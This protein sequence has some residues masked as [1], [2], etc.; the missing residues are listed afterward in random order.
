MKSST[1]RTLKKIFLNITA[2]LFALIF[3]GNIIAGENAGQINQVLGTKTSKTISTLPAGQE[4]GYAR[5]FDSAFTSIAQLKAAGEAKV[6]EVEGEGIVLLK[7]DNAVLPLASGS[8]V[9]LVGVTVMDPVYGGTGSGAVDADGAP[10]YY[11]VLTGAGYDVVDKA[12]LDY[13]VENEAKRNTYEIGE[14]R[15]KKVSKNNDDTIGQGEDAI[16]VVGRVGGEG[17]DVTAEKEDALDGDYLTLNEDEISILEG[18]K[19]LKDDGDIRS[20]T[21]IINSANPIST[22]F[23]YDKDYGVD[24]ALW[25]GSVGQ[26]GLYAVG[27]VL[28]GAVNPSGSLPDTWW[29]D[30]KLDPVMNNFGSYTYADAD[31]YNFPALS[32]YGKYVVYQEGIYV[33][34]KYTETRYEDVI[35]ETPGVGTFNYNSV[36]AYPFGYGLSY[37][38]FELSN[39]KAEVSGEGQSKA[40]TLT[41]DVTNTGDAAGKKTVQIYAQK[42]Y[43]D[44]DRANQIE[45]AAVELVG[46]GKTAILQP[47]ESETI[48][49]SVPEYYLTSFDTFGTGVYILDEGTYYLT[50]ADNAHAAV[51]NIL[52]AKGY[53][54]RPGV[55]GNADLAWSFE[56]AFDSTT[57]SSAYGTGTKVSPLFAAADMNRYEGKGDNSISYYT[58][59][60]WEN[61][62]T[63]GPVKL[64]MT[65]QMAKDVVLNDEDLPAAGGEFPTMGKNANLQLINMMDYAFDDPM[66][67]TFMDQLT[68]EE[69]A[70][71]T[72]TGLRE[73]VGVSSIGKPGTI[74]HN[75]PS[76]VTQKYSI[77]ANGFATVLN[78]PDK[79]LKGTCY[80]CN[81]IVAATFN[82]K[83]VE[84]VG[85]LIGEDAMWAG[86]AGLYG[87]G[88]N[89]HRSPYAGRVFE[90]YSEDGMLTGLIDTVETKGIQS[91]GVYV[92]N[93]HFVM[94]D[95]E[96][97]RAGI[98]TWIPEQALRENY[99]RAFEL[100]IVNADA[101]CVMT[102]YNRLGTNW[103]G[104]Y[105]ALLLDWL[106]G[107]AG[108]DGFAVSDMYDSSYMVPVNEI[109]A[110][111]DIPDGELDLASLSAYGPKG[112]TP[113]A[114][115]A[116]A[117]RDASKR[118]LYTVLH[119][120]GMDG[121]SANTK[122][123]SVTPWW[124][125]TLN[126]AQWA[127]LALT[128]LAAVL[129]ILDIAKEKKRA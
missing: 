5:Y 22:G 49:V 63:T 2:V 56:Q 87:T 85:E 120:R 70:S 53:A 16:F 48:T 110:G 59:S 60:D 109:V 78:D 47:G 8:K 104:A 114:A 98:G 27:D 103:C 36:V 33:G 57:Y 34:Y 76:G 119:S 128:V 73:T 124:Q 10:N 7:N 54:D 66:W 20:I 115:V 105:S 50:A 3:T 32:A 29:M 40:Y 46:Y 18:L 122:V 106:R 30:N 95:Q 112:A 17:D 12:L 67:E 42:P 82:D 13:Y 75:G 117:M 21:V 55:T 107:E 31:T 96:N 35:L 97:N 69:M 99:L 23:L 71:I 89:I 72:L 25:V 45:K 41:V 1:R 126:I 65:A 102:G 113:N 26:T 61:S 121:I 38:T 80:P 62:L 77:G 108:M 15:W 116:H 51:N 84:E 125:L 83:L 86:Y 64:T 94:N 91:K 79:D 4:E 9:S 81:G 68:Y 101:K 127:L 6:R 37:T 28:S 90:Y 19:E 92:Y 11:D 43:T 74:D 44:Y 93:K 52:S 88:L 118:V 129:L 58:R 24:A 123:V 111:N 100:P 39:L 14:V